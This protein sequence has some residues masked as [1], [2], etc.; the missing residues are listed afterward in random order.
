MNEKANI[1]SPEFTGSPM[2]P[3]ASISTN[4]TRI[5]N[6]AY[7]QTKMGNLAPFEATVRAS[8][9]YSAGDYVYIAS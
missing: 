3:N 6:T 9:N 1:D 4:T 2:A 5:A 8:K 7:V